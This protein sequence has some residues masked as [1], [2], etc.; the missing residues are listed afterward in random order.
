MQNQITGDAHWDA[1]GF[2]DEQRAVLERVFG[3]NRYT[4]LL[5]ARER[6]LVQPLSYKVFVDA[7]TRERSIRC[8]CS[9]GF[10]GLTNEAEDLPIG[11]L[12]SLSA[13]SDEVKAIFARYLAIEMDPNL[14]SMDA[15][16]HEFHATLN[17]FAA[18]HEPLSGCA[19]GA[20]CLI[21]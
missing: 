18:S 9:D 17:A 15:L 11:S 1:L 6:W 12:Y 8:R 7:A 10:E 4:M 3:D 21:Y 14:A 16:L 19:W 13:D 20:A 2:G 5:Y